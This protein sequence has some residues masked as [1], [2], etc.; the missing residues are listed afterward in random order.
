M[1]MSNWSR[2]ELK[3]K[4]K[5]GI[6]KYYLEAVG[7]SIILGL[8]GIGRNITADNSAEAAGISVTGDVAGLAEILTEEELAVLVMAV[9]GA[10]ALA[11]LIGFVIKLFVMNVIQV[12]GC[13]FYLESQKNQQSAGIGKL[14]WGFRSGGYGNLVKI[15]LI[16]DIKIML[17]SILF[18]IPGIIKNFEYKMIPYIL[19]E[20]P[21]I[22][23]A[24]AFAKSRQMMKGNKWKLFVLELSFIGWY[25]LAAFV[26][27]ILKVIPVVGSILLS[28]PV[29]C[30][31][32]YF[33]ATHAE[34]YMTLKD[35]RAEL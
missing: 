7:V 20:E 19:A 28:L 3:Q 1:R 23:C 32:P 33:D 16:K 35:G 5:T 24:E 21:N 29:F 11:T 2:A 15:M 6:K 13:R 31:A 26:G 14:F 27:F 30:L 22:S 10:A 25:F 17:W 34:L 9:L 8:L 12:G 18:V 4:A